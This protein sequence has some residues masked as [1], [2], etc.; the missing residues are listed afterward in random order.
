MSTSSTGFPDKPVTSCVEQKLALSQ[1]QGA[2]FGILVLPKGE[3]VTLIPSAPATA[4][5]VTPA[6]EEQVAQVFAPQ[7]VRVIPAVANEARAFQQSKNGISLDDAVIQEIKTLQAEWRNRPIADD[8]A[9]A[10]KKKKKRFS[11]QKKN[12]PVK[13][14]EKA[15]SRFDEEKENDD[16]QETDAT[17][18]AV[19]MKKKRAKKSSAQS[20]FIKTKE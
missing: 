13:L 4:Q 11:S 5:V 20:L 9:D 8:G 12:D 17:E 3:S 14:R 15:K 2:G 10:N 19:L 16:E 7:S 1:Q 6:S 18:K